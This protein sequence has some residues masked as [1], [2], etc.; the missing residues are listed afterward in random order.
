MRRVYTTGTVVHEISVGHLNEASLFV[1]NDLPDDLLVADSFRDLGF[2]PTWRV[3]A[4]VHD[5]Q[6]EKKSCFTSA[7]KTTM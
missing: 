3:A 5:G 1:M 4:L 7:T 2:R 6:A